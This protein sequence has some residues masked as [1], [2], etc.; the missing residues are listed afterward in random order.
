[1]DHGMTCR[2][3]KT[4]LRQTAATAAA[5]GCAAVEGTPLKGG[6]FNQVRQASV[7]K[8]DCGSGSQQLRV[9][10]R[11]IRDGVSIETA[12]LLAGV[13]ITEARL[14]VADDL[15]HPPEPSDYQLLGD[16]EVL[17]VLCSA[18]GRP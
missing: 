15:R 13:S 4:Q 11:S 8:L 16:A 5:K 10:R 1:M 9:F 6:P 12:A 14:I 2:S 17:L 18:W 7:R 3:P